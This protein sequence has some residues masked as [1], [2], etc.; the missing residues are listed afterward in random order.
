MFEAKTVIKNKFWI[1]EEN[2]HQIGTIQAV[3][4]G[5]VLVHGQ[6]REKFPSLRLLASKH[7][8]KVVSRKTRQQKSENTVYDY[9]CDGH[10]YNPVYD[11]KSKLPLYTK[12]EKSKSYYCAGH[13]LILVEE[14]WL[15]VFCPKKIILS[16]HKFLGPFKNKDALNQ[17]LKQ[18]SS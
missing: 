11:V 16:R 15:G 10:P 5:V 4:D 3:P 7:N 8:I 6:T 13:Y 14:T 12:E 9:P 2:G 17:Q 18:I 1:V